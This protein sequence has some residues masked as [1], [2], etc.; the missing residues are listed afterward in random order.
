MGQK[1]RRVDDFLA[2]THFSWMLRKILNFGDI[3]QQCGG[4]VKVL[5][6]GQFSISKMYFKLLGPVP[7][8]PWKR[9]FCNNGAS[10]KSVF[11]TW[12]SS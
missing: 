1:G 11:I 5:C 7:H 3:V 9:I 4:W 10:P 8:V 6:R 2:P 12:S